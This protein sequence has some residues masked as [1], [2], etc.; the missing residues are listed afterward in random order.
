M[1]E[2]STPLMTR[3]GPPGPPVRQINLVESTAK[4]TQRSPYQMR[5]HEHMLVHMRISHKRISHICIM[6]DIRDGPAKTQLIYA[7]TVS[8]HRMLLRGA[9]ILVH[10]L[11]RD[12]DTVCNFYR[13]YAKTAR[14]RIKTCA[15]ISEQPNRIWAAFSQRKPS[16]SR[17]TTYAPILGDFPRTGR[18]VKHIG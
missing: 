15:T 17:K 12:D 8:H 7:I 4:T 14:V 3:D 10:D 13:T 16:T 1:M 18:I 6:D 11:R 2:A 5:P 9:H